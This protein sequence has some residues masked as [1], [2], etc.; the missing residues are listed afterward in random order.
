MCLI[1]AHTISTED[2]AVPANIPADVLADSPAERDTLEALPSESIA[3][4]PAF[5]F[6]PALSPSSTSALPNEREDESSSIDVETAPEETAPSAEVLEETV[7]LPE[8]SKCSES[9]GYLSCVP[10]LGKTQF[11]V[12]L[13][14]EQLSSS[15]LHLSPES[16]MH[17]FFPARLCF[18]FQANLWSEGTKHSMIFS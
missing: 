9:S 18:V 3:V 6:A 11:Y 16:H 5:D 10:F 4:Q 13:D 7:P 1:W 17:P 2:S 15:V 12:Q 8:T 14:P